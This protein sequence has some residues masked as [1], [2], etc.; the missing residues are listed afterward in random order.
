MIDKEL[1]HSNA[2]L[3]ENVSLTAK[4]DSTKVGW[5]DIDDKLIDTSISSALDSLPKIEYIRERNGS[6]YKWDIFY[7]IQD[8]PDHLGYLSYRRVDD[9]NISLGYLYVLSGEI[10]PIRVK[11]LMIEDRRQI[12]KDAVTCAKLWVDKD[13]NVGVFYN[14][15]S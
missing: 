7:V 1:I 4:F 6:F 3:E 9:K 8:N 11:A 10:N 2:E 15:L 12:L 14:E 5:A 13:H